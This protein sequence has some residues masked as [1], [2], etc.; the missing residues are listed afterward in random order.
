[1]YI[2]QKNLDDFEKIARNILEHKLPD[3]TEQG[4]QII[5]KK[6]IHYIGNILF[7]VYNKVINTKIM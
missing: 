6:N 3:L 5:Q 7:N 2:R 4:Y 1:M